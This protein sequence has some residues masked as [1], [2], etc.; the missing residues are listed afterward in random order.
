MSLHR[1]GRTPLVAGMSTILASTLIAVPL[2]WRAA[3]PQQFQT[4]MSD[5]SIPTLLDR[6][7]KSEK[8]EMCKDTKMKMLCW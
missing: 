2:I 8:P 3:E 6:M 1:Q 4:Q 5:T 7:T